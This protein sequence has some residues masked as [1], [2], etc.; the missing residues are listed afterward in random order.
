MAQSGRS[1]PAPV[2][3][4]TVLYLKRHHGKQMSYEDLSMFWLYFFIVFLVMFVLYIP[5]DMYDRHQRKLHAQHQSEM[6]MMVEIDDEPEEVSI[7]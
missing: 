1:S 5:I 3:L 7:V 4:C 2:S 6:Q